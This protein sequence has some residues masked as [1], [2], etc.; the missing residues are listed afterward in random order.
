MLWRY[1][2]H[3]FHSYGELWLARGNY[4]KALAY[5]GDCL[6]LAEGSESRKNIVKAR[7]LR[8]QVFLSQGKLAEAE[9][10]FTATLALAQEVGNPPQLWKTWAALG[11][12]RRAQSGA[13][14]AG[15]AHREA[16][17]VIEHV[18]GGLTDEQL[19]Q[20]FLES[21]QVQRIRDAARPV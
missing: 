20:T 15:A 18:A 10:E 1:A 17:T 19:R 8:G 16:L 11:D 5:A 4:E 14:Q 21:R 7:R 2:Q 12:L 6:D 9:Q 3:L 13:E